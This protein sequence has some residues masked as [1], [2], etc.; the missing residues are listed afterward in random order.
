MFFGAAITSVALGLA[1][2][3]RAATHSALGVVFLA[4]AAGMVL[5]LLI[6]VVRKIRGAVRS[7]K[8]LRRALEGEAQMQRLIYGQS[9]RRQGATLCGFFGG[10]AVT[11]ATI[12]FK[13]AEGR[14]TYFVL[15]SLCTAGGVGLLAIC[16]RLISTYMHVRAAQR[17]FGLPTEEQGAQRKAVLNQSASSA[18]EAPMAIDRVLR[19]PR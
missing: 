14:S 8:R 2:D 1:I 16:M 19:D 7:D 11:F 10:L 15:G 3:H 9:E 6:A 17:H 4:G 18:A 12:F 5:W 13:F